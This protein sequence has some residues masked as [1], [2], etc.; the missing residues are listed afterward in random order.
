MFAAVVV[1]IVV[2][3]D[4]E[5]PALL[6]LGLV[7]FQL[8]LAVVAGVQQ[9]KALKQTKACV[10]AV[11]AECAVQAV[12]VRVAGVRVE[13]ASAAVVVVVVQLF[14]LE[15]QAHKQAHRPQVSMVLLLL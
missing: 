13:R 3:V 15:K 5:L 9:A 11:C 6:C 4:V 14:A 1:V 10:V 2:V 8:A 12:F 7:R